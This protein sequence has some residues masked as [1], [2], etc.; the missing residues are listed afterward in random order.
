[1]PL[2]LEVIAEQAGVEFRALPNRLGRMGAV[3]VARA[4]LGPLA[5]Y[6]DR[7]LGL[8]GGGSV[9][10]RLTAAVR[11]MADR[12]EIRAEYST[13]HHHISTYC[14]RAGVGYRWRAFDGEQWRP[15]QRCLPVFRTVEPNGFL[16]TVAVLIPRPEPDNRVRLEEEFSDP[17]LS[18]P[19]DVYTRYA[20]DL[21]I[22]YSGFARLAEML[23][24][25]FGLPSRPRLDD[26]AEAV[27]AGLAERGELGPALPP[28][29]NRDRLARWCREAG[30]RAYEGGSPR[31]HELL[32]G[33]GSPALVL[34]VV[35]RPDWR[36][37]ILSC[38]ESYRTG[39][40]RHGGALHEVTAP[41]AELP[42]LVREFERRLAL[43]AAPG[44][45]DDRFIACLAALVTR[46]TLG[47]GLPRRGN[48][49]VLAEW[50]AAAGVTPARSDFGRTEHLVRVHREATKCVH[51]LVLTIDA[52]NGIG[53]HEKYDYLPLRDDAGREYAYSV[54]T[55]YT[56]LAAL[57]AHF[58]AATGPGELDDRL[59]RCFRDLVAR[60]RL[61]GELELREARNRVQKWFKQAG[62]PAEPADWSWVN[63]D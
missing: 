62:V 51:E 12:R 50:I 53:F 35:F 18:Y 16:R 7:R 22:P 63:S 36:P 44:Q 54:R 27:F 28:A 24:R 47:D 37:P 46:G 55:P 15:G 31:R 61:T 60:G 38:T 1:M 25:S 3:V 41:L 32:R 11:A 43:P 13:N 6:L 19:D 23:E 10:Q 58:E 8:P 40:L 29:G 17:A 30:V 4:D 48:R 5:D 26:R 34:E 14:Q 56:S 49:D 39:D 45:L 20:Y 57:V 52:R 42:T 9:E 21:S 59:I 33:A 2:P